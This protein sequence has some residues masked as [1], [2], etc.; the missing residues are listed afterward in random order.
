MNGIP[1]HVR[2]F[3]AIGQ[4]KAN[5]FSGQDS[6]PTM[7]PVLESFVEQQ[8]KSEANSQ[9]GSA[10][11][12]EI[13]DRLGEVSSVDFRHCVTECPDPGQNELLRGSDC[14]GIGSDLRASAHFLDRL[15]NA[16]EISHLVVDDGD[17][18]TVFALVNKG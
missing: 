1:T 11:L 2:H 15:L 7:C 4:F 12:D 16:A 13:A 8:L 5:D 14:M 9:K 17:H 18:L 3:Q 6:Q 10:G